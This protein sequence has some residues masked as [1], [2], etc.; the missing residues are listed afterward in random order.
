MNKSAIKAFVKRTLGCTCPDKVFDEIRH[1]AD[2][3]LAQC[4]SPVSRIAVGDRLLIYLMC[5][6]SLETVARE[7]PVMIRDGQAERDSCG[8]NRFRAVVCT[9]NIGA[10]ANSADAVFAR[11]TAKDD[12]VHLHVVTRE[13]V[14]D[15]V[16][17]DG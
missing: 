7:L 5:T 12:R 17:A 15:I 10:V 9:G 2:A 11:N 14:R 3:S 8:F 16:A 6:D 4:E 1:E 13:Q